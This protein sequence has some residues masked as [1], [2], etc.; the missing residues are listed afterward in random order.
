MPLGG[1]DAYVNVAGGLRLDDPG[2]DLAVCAA[3]ASAFLGRPIPDKTAFIGEVGLTGEVRG[4]QLLQQRIAE[5]ASLGFETIY[6]S[7]VGTLQQPEKLK[8][9][10]VHDITSLLRG[11]FG[12]RKRPPEQP[13][14]DRRQ[15][16][17]DLRSIDVRQ[18]GQTIV[19][20]PRPRGTRSSCLQQGQR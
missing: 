12:K 17:Y 13:S 6:V 15:Y 1:Q 7:D 10:R 5:G 8:I 2:A 16:S 18:R 19:I 14:G 4:A 3:V 20:F 11:L 9:V